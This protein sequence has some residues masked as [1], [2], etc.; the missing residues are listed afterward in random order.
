MNTT[1]RSTGIL[2]YALRRRFAFVTLPSK[3]SVIEKFYSD[4]DNKELGD[5]AVTLFRD[6]KRFIEDPKHLCSDM[7]IDDLMVGHSYFMAESEDE[8]RDKVE[9]EI[10]PLIKEYINDGIL[11]VKQDEKKTAF[12]AWLSLSTIPSVEDD[13]QE[14]NN[15]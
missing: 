13:K 1:D 7:S 9:Y 11:S 10:L 6:I 15:E 8:L 2:D 5:I 12:G 4:A 14:D 3:E